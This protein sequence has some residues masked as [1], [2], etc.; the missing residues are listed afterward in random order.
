MSTNNWLH[1]LDDTVNSLKG[2]SDYA[3]TVD[4]EKGQL[5]GIWAS[6]FQVVL[7]KKYLSYYYIIREPTLLTK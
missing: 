7:R 4:H 1:V 2:N 6:Q 5:K 3:Q